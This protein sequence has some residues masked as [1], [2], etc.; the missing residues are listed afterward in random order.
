MS[1]ARLTV[2]RREI[3]ADVGHA[4]QRWSR[5]AAFSV[6]ARAGELEGEGEVVPLPGFSND[7]PEAVAQAL[8]ALDGTDVWVDDGVPAVCDALDAST[9]FA[10]S[11]ACLDLVAKRRGLPLYGWLGGAG[12]K[13]PLSMLLPIDDEAAAEEALARGA[14]RGIDAFKIK[15]GADVDAEL[16]IVAHVRRLAP[17]ASLRVD[18]N[19]AFS[20]DAVPRILGALADLG[21]MYVEEPVP[22]H[23]LDAVPDWPV[24]LALDESLPRLSPRSRR[25]F[26][27]SGRVGA[28]VLK[29]ALLGGIDRALALAH[30]AAGYEIGASA[31]HL[32]DGPIGLA[33]ACA[34]ALAS[35][36]PLAAGCAPHVG[37]V[38]F[39][40]RSIA[41]LGDAAV[42][43]HREVGLGLEASR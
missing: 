38:A 20:R 25:M 32:F 13:V 36:R 33:A 27:E 40:P 9:R 43:G 18:A 35:P 5:R 39:A 31:S 23:T 8:F 26:F 6:V 30:I 21:V 7:D 19:G 22:L 12:A 28:V 2:T 17:D 42:H 4:T 16:R 34:L 41:A 1:E 11:T 3:E 37:L 15:M 14:A 24:P 29:P 10:V